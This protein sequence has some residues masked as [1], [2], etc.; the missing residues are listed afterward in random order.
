MN[1]IGYRSPKKLSRRGRPRKAAAKAAA[2]EAEE[3]FEH[4]RS[5][6]RRGRPRK[7]VAAKP[8]TKRRARPPRSAS[9]AELNARIKELEK[10]HRRLARRLVQLERNLKKPLRDVSSRSS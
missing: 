6:S 4:L 10:S 2:P 7:S 9:G 3:V 8:A 5:A 1:G